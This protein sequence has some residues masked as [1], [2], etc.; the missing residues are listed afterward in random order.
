EALADPVSADARA[1]LKELDLRFVVSP[2]NLAGAGEPAS[3]FIEQARFDDSVIYEVVWTPESDAALHDDVATTEPPLP[4]VPPFKVGERAA[5][6]VQWLNGPLDLTAGQ[7]TLSVVAAEARDLGVA[8]EPPAW[9][10]EVGVD[11]APWVSR[12]FEAHDRFRTAADAQLRPLLHQRAL[13]EGRRAVDRA[14]SYDHPGR[15]VSSGDSPAAARGPDA[16]ALPLPPGA[17]DA[18]TALWY[19]RTMPVSPGYALAMPLNEAGRTLALTVTVPARETIVIDGAPVPALRLE[20]RFT[21][22]VQRRQP[23]A[24]TIWLSDDARRVPLMVEVAAGFGRVRLKL[25]DYRP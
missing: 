5:Y 23:I 6:D 25:V 24:S 14:Y 15:R 2:A 16:L 17:R 8:G 3:P 10:F 22:R 12:F 20:P 21:A 13:R 19:I 1:T 18:L 7:I 11:T 9:V 4:G